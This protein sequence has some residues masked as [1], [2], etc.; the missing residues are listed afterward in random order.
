[1]EKHKIVGMIIGILAFVALIAGLTYAWYTWQSTNNTNVSFTVG[2]VD[3]TFDA[4]SDITSSKLKPVSS[5][6]VGVSKGYAIEKTITASSTMTSYLNLYLTLDTLPDELKEESF[7][8]EMYKGNELVSQGNFKNYNQGDKIT[9]ASNQKITS[10]IT[11]YKLYIWIDGNQSNPETMQNQ[12]FNFTLN[13]DATDQ[14]P[15]N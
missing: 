4:G 12:T 6:E 8:W 2:G 5:K 15:S 7:I 13:A 11:T 1:M 14:T 3:I 9:V 10:T